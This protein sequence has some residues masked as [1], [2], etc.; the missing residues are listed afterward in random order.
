MKMLLLRSIPL[1]SSTKDAWRSVGVEIVRRRDH[2][3]FAELARKA[4]AVINAGN[5]EENLANGRIFNSR[6]AIRAIS[7]P[8]ALR[9]TLHDYIP[10]LDYSGPHWHKP[11]GWGG[12]NKVFHSQG[13]DGCERFD[14]DIQRHI[15]GTEYRVIT[16]GA[17]LVQASRK[18]RD[19]DYPVGQFDWH[20]VGLDGIRDS[21]IISHIKSATQEIPDWP[22][23]VFGWDVILADKPYVIEIN[24]SPGV[25]EAS[26]NRIVE[27]IGKVL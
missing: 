8:M 22:D 7:S 2:H 4:D 24:T 1:A 5:L 25:N 18:D 9:R 13:E 21:G 23:T 16:V 20:W 15:S 17:T 26:A 14:G 3:K 6:D 11:G 27:Q 19:A 12:K 10:D